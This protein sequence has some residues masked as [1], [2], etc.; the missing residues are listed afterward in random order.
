MTII[1]VL[2]EE[3]RSEFVRILLKYGFTPEKAEK[4][5]SI[6]AA[7]TLDGISSHG[8]NRF[9]RFIRYIEKGY[10]DVHAEPSLAHQAGALEQ[11]KGNLGP[12]PLNAL[13]STERAMQ[14]AGEHGI[15]L[16]GLAQTN[17]WMRGGTYGWHAARAGFIFFGWSNTTPNMPAWGAVNPKL[18]NNP[19][20]IA[21]PYGNE[22]MVLDMAMSQYSFGKMEEK[23]LAGEKLPTPGGFDTAGQLTD[24]PGEI[25]ESWRSLPIGY[26][27]G[28]ALSLLL[29]LLAA[30][31]SGGLTTAEIGQKE[32]EY[33]V[34]QVFIAID[35]QKLKNYPSIQQ[36]LDAT[37]EDLKTS[38]LID[39]NVPVRYPGERIL[40]NRAENLKKGIPVD[41]KIWKEIING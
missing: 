4:C 32:E 41:R 6:F 17:H 24:D 33:S 19:L 30:I 35:P 40:N 39:E 11:W 3:M 27:K 16:V 18:G 34:S 25:L 29:D 22:A 21:I 31:L 10:I 37:V 9:P 14:L 15:G 5:A 28:A 13:F 20:V 2:Y 8:I 36:V 38:L 23:Q 12:G 1:R 26:W 7:N